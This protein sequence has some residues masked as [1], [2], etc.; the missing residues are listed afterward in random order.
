[1]EKSPKST[2]ALL[3]CSVWPDEGSDISLEAQSVEM[4]TYC[5]MNGLEVLDI[6]SDVGPHIK[7]KLR[8][9]MEKLLSKA[10]HEGVGHV[11]IHDVARVGRDSKEVLT[12]LR[13]TFDHNHTEV[14][15]CAWKTSTASAECGRILS[16]VGEIVGLDHPD[17]LK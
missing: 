4:Q 1:M 15:V 13:D 2:K 14:H 7:G 9:G 17:P 12:F 6:I 16:R 10:M 5:L 8:S 11:V 3:Y